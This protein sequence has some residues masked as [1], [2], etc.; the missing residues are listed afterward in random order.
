MSDPAGLDAKE[1]V[2]WVAS[3]LGAL[4][5]GAVAFL[6]RLNG[7]TKKEVL[8]R[9]E[10]VRAELRERQDLD[11]NSATARDLV[12][13][14]HIDDLWGALG[15]MEVANRDANSRVFARLDLMSERLGQMP[16]REEMRQD[17]NDMEKRLTEAFHKSR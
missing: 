1:I 2:G 16:T 6:W 14:K 8:S 10:A 3:G 17:R 9:V 4:A 12:Y 5:S 7:D 13:Q 11:R 15:K